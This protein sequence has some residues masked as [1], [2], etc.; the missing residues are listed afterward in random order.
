MK[1]NDFINFDDVKLE[2]TQEID[3]DQLVEQIDSCEA[4][5]LFELHNDLN[6]SLVLIQIKK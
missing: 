1:N 6:N 2:E 3:V 5:R 4:F